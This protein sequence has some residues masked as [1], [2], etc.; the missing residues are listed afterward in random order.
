MSQLGTIL[1]EQHR[2]EEANHYL[3]MAAENVL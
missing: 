2:Y 1:S 3:R